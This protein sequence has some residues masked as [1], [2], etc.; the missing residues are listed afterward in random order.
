MRSSFALLAL[1]LMPALPA[2]QPEPATVTIA[3]L[4]LFHPQVLILT[5]PTAAM[6]RL[7]SASVILPAGEPLR[8]RADSGHVIAQLAGQ[9]DKAAHQITLPSGWFHLTVPHKLDRLYSG[10]LTLT[11]HDQE[12]QPIV[13]ISTETAVASIV[14]AESPADAAPE[15]LKAQAIVARSFL[16]ATPHRH[17]AFTA[18]DTTHCQYLRAAPPPASPALRAAAAT[19]GLVLTW[20]PASSSAPQTIAALYSRSCGGTTHVLH[21]ASADAYPFFAVRCGYCQ[22]HPE[23][24]TRFRPQALPATERERI[25]FNRSHG[26]AAIPSTSYEASGSRLEGRGTGHGFGLCQLGAQDLARRGQTAIAILSHY[27]PAAGVTRLP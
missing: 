15:A 6:L 24:W 21:P 13:S 11:A 10:A 14:A 2:Q 12:L 1:L 7:D 17:H 4:S 5:T 23:K 9:P 20:Q 18:C 8:L 3:V 26:W 27:F 25:A 19:A 16:L 22:R